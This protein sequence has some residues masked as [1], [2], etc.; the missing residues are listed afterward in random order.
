MTDLEN[1]AIVAQFPKKKE[2]K[3]AVPFRVGK[4]GKIVLRAMGVI[5]IIS[6]IGAREAKA[7]QPE[8][9][10]QKPSQPSLSVESDAGLNS[11][12]PNT[13]SARL[14]PDPRTG[15][16]DNLD[17]D[18]LTIDITQEELESELARAPK[19]LDDNPEQGGAGP[20][21]I[22]GEENSLG[23]IGAEYSQLNLP[24]AVIDSL[25]DTSE[26]FN[27]EN[28]SIFYTLAKNPA[29][30]VY[31]I[32]NDT[33]NN[34]NFREFV[35]QSSQLSEAISQILEYMDG[36]EGNPSFRI[37]FAATNW[38][39]DHASVTVLATFTDQVRTTAGSEISAGS[40]FLIGDNGQEILVQPE[41]GQ[42]VQ[43]LAYT[44]DLWNIMVFGNG[45]YSLVGRQPQDNEMVA[46][47]VNE[48]DSMPVK[49]ITGDG[50][51]HDLENQP[52]QIPA[53]LPTQPPTPVPTGPNTQPEGGG[54]SPRPIPAPQPAPTEA[55]GTGITP[56]PDRNVED[57]PTDLEMPS[58]ENIL[59]NNYKTFI[60]EIYRAYDSNWSWNSDQWEWDRTAMAWK[61]LVNDYL[62]VP[63]LATDVEEGDNVVQS[64]RINGEIAS[65]ST[66][67]SSDYVRGSSGLKITLNLSANNPGLN[68]IDFTS[69]Q[70][71]LDFY[72]GQAVEAFQDVLPGRHLVI[73]AT[74]LE[75]PQT[76]RNS[77]SNASNF[78]MRYSNNLAMLK[79]GDYGDEII[80]LN[81]ANGI[82][83]DN[84]AYPDT[85]GYLLLGDALSHIVFNYSNESGDVILEKFRQMTDNLF[86]RYQR[87]IVTI[88]APSLSH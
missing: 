17:G 49:I 35:S 10:S 82:M 8:D 45:F 15:N 86:E 12:L 13:D 27:Y 83:R 43:F 76:R 47:V 37:N 29:T 59:M 40:I 25:T 36:L 78:E 18:P 60:T 11:P 30:G 67:A 26:R 80:I 7:S 56:E 31:E 34:D 87:E 6:A 84:M 74:D 42:R 4:F 66:G 52:E 79:L 50:T 32:L 1:E 85:I 75:N 16:H 20:E 38:G 70:E 23:F 68:S 2:T 44:Y 9:T 62:F 39:T 58:S 57:M 54:Q 51:V 69:N 61:D 22:T 81:V 33:Y 53:A 41:P 24:S 64:H 73:N 77:R 71:M 28:I 5:T 19:R 65:T 14:G 21:P 55:A 88:A 46:L 3:S 63:G 48:S 72:L